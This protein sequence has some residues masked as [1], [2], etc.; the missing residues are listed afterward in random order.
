MS[1]TS[2]T[3]FSL[4]SLG[5]TGI[6]SLFLGILPLYFNTFPLTTPDAGGLACAA[7]TLARTGHFNISRTNSPNFAICWTTSYPVVQIINAIAIRLLP[8]HSWQVIPLMTTAA[9]LVCVFGIYAISFRL[10]RSLYIS[11]LTAVLASA[12]PALL[13][14]ATFTPQNVYG[15]AMIVII[16]YLLIK[17]IQD[18]AKLYWLGVGG[19][20]IILAFTHTLSFGIAAIAFTVWIW[21]F[22]LESWW[23]RL[24]TLG[25]GIGILMLNEKMT[26]LPVTIEAAWSLF[27]GHFSGYDQ[28]V[29]Y[30]PAHWGYI[31]TMLACIGLAFS[32]RLHYKIK[33]LL[34]T[35][36]IVPVVLAHLS[37]IGIR[38]QPDRFVPFAWISLVLLAGLGLAGVQQHLRLPKFIWETCVVLMLGAQIVHA[39]VFIQDDITGWSARFRPHPEFIEAVQWLNTQPTKGALL[40]I[41][42]VSNREISFAPIWYDGMIENYPWYNLDHKNIKNLQAKSS[43]YKPILENPADPEYTRIHALYA[44][45]TGPTDPTVPARIAPYNLKY[46]IL[47]KTSQAYK[48]WKNEAAIPFPLIYENS[49]YVLYTLQ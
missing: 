29:Y 31:I 37:F 15:Y 22:A 45:I 23:Y 36:L 18:Q 34:L 43:L 25:S 42:A 16:T 39:V 17:I 35:L 11:T 3:T 20:M 19:C 9:F 41:M 28:P 13:H 12:S 40:G 7:D 4:I 14:T 33:W 38:L 27:H 1:S 49:K 6:I 10:T 32:I 30:H 8:L 2:S 46:F 47:P 5:V 48:I 24:I 44:L 21:I 26:F